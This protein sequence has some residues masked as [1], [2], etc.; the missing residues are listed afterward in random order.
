MDAIPTGLSMPLV[1]T[2]PIKHVC[3]SVGTVWDQAGGAL[4][5]KTQ[6]IENR[7]CIFIRA[8]LPMLLVLTLP[9]KHVCMSV[10]TVWDQVG[11]T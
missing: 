10:G 6:G 2:L 1:W 7:L 8:G 3:L 11:G 4:M 9:I 5:D